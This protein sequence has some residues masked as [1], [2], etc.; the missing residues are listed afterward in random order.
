MQTLRGPLI[1]RLCVVLWA[2]VQRR[3]PHSAI[4]FRWGQARLYQHFP[5]EAPPRSQA[6]LAVERATACAQL[7][8]PITTVWILQLRCAREAVS[9][10]A[11]CLSGM[12]FPG[13][14]PFTSEPWLGRRLA[15]RYAA[16]L[17]RPAPSR[18]VV[19]FRCTITFALP[20]PLTG[21][22]LAEIYIETPSRPRALSRWRSSE[23]PTL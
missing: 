17:A 18:P 11:P 12:F 13:G 23:G 7:R 4:A 16:D 15:S 1:G 2:L 22:L 20:G 21:R 8:A 19:L 5:P 10:S 3:V 14:P 6:W 9:S